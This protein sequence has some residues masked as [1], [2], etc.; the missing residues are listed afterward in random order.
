MHERPT[1]NFHE[2]SF[3]LCLLVAYHE[4]LMLCLLLLQLSVG[5][6][7]M[8]PTAKPLDYLPLRDCVMQAITVVEECPHH[9]LLMEFVLWVAT[10]NR[11]LSLVRGNLPEVT[12]YLCKVQHFDMELSV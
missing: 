6:V 11:G 9:V 8:A 2:R 7:S 4:L 3:S 10:V 5:N 1:S 12:V